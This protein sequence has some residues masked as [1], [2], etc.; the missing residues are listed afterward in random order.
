MPGIPQRVH[1]DWSNAWPYQAQK[2]RDNYR[3]AV[4]EIVRL[5]LVDQGSFV[6]YDKISPEKLR[7][8]CEGCQPT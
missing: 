1:L 2:I 3:V 4:D 6:S 5:L 7:V 8:L